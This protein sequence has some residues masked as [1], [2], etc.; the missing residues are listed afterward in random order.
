MKYYQLRPASTTKRAA[1]FGPITIPVEDISGAELPE[2]PWNF[3]KGPGPLPEGCLADAELPEA[4]L[5]AGKR[6]PTAGGYALVSAAEIGYPTDKEL[7]TWLAEPGLYRPQ[8]R[9]ALVLLRGR[10]DSRLKKTAL[11]CAAVGDRHCSLTAEAFQVL[12]E[13]KGDPEVEHFFIDYFVSL[14]VPPCIHGGTQDY[15]TDIAHSFWE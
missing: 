8:L 15:L 12:A 2:K 11:Q 9:A 3:A 7:E 1:C 14:D 10:G 6:Y 4:L 5:I 13:L